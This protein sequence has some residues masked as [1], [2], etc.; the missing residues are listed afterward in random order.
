MS[1]SSR[2]VVFVDPGLLIKGIL[3][4]IAMVERSTITRCAFLLMACKSATS[5]LKIIDGG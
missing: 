3:K 4:E 1:I 2:K 5:Q